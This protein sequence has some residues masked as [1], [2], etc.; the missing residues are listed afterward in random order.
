M[1]DLL[2]LILSN[3]GWV[4]GGIGAIALAIFTAFVRKSGSDAEKAKQKEA[5][6]KAA[7]TVVVEKQKVKAASN[8]EIAHG[9]TKWTR[10]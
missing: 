7:Q 1:P 6:R 8:D 3:L 9:V 5:D 4:L 2:S 10:R